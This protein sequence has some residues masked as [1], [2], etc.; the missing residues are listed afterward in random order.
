[1]K[2]KKP[3]VGSARPVEG[4]LAMPPPYSRAARVR[5]D[6]VGVIAHALKEWL[7][8]HGLPVTEIYEVIEA[9]VE[10]EIRIAVQDA[11]QEIRRH[12]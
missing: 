5:Q 12:D 10:E 9:R 8:G 3:R 2:N 11:L 4:E 6:V 7:N 1:M